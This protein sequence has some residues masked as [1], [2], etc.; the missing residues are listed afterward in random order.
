MSE[1]KITL[2]SQTTTAEINQFFSGLGKNDRVR[3]RSSRDG[4]ELYVRGSSSWHIFTDTFR[5]GKDVRDDY[6]KA[7]DHLAQIFGEKRK[8]SDLGIYTLSLRELSTRTRTHQHDFRAADLKHFLQSAAH[9]L[10]LETAAEHQRQSEAKHR[11]NS[12]WSDTSFSQSD[13]RLMQETVKNWAIDTALS[14][15]PESAAIQ[16]QAREFCTYLDNQTR[17][18]NDPETLDYTAAEN[19]AFSWKNGLGKNCS[20]MLTEAAK[21]GETLLTSL[22][23]KISEQS[24]PERVDLSAGPIGESAADLIIMDPHAKY[25]GYIGMTMSS[26]STSSSYSL[27]NQNQNDPIDFSLKEHQ[28]IKKTNSAEI[29]HAL[30]IDYESAFAYDEQFLGTLYAQVERAIAKKMALN[31]AQSNGKY[32]IHM[33]ILNPSETELVSQPTT[34]ALRYFVGITHQWLE[35]YPNLH[36]KVQLPPGISEQDLLSIYR[37]ASARPTAASHPTGIIDH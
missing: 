35:K 6:K 24:L 31:E 10:Q 12:S 19:F 16:Q 17:S 3:A 11:L 36:I 23:S 13:W 22:T 9:E 26:T 5:S 37:N 15:A 20:N 18:N 34:T 1:Q 2:N 32:T 7:K 27:R 4:V 8:N 21:R 30:E 14:D 28:G 33:T 25:P 29:D